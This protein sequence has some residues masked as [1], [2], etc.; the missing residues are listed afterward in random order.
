MCRLYQLQAPIKHS[1]LAL[2]FAYDAFDIHEDCRPAT[3]LEQICI[4]FRRLVLEDSVRHSQYDRIILISAF[5]RIC[6]N[7][8]LKPLQ[9]CPSDQRI[10][11][12]YIDFIVFQ[13]TYQ[14]CHTGIADIAH[15]LFKGRSKDQGLCSS[16]D[17]ARLNQKLYCF[18][19]NIKSHGVINS[20]S[21]QN[22]F[23]VVAQLLRFVSQIIGINWDTVT[24]HQASLKG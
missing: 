4:S 3:V 15:I 23:G 20:P 11:H 18:L 5:E 13:L 24:A 14:L 22:N 7:W 1:F 21:R 6:Q 8:N 10:M 9:L 16:Y 17:S 12:G 2:H 19:G